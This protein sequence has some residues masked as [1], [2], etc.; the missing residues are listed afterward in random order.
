MSADLVAF[1]RAR[2]D[3]DERVARAVLGAP[4]VRRKDVAGVHADD[5]TD[6]RPDGTP[7]ADCRHVP[8]EYEHKVAVAEHIARHQPARVLAEVEAKRRIVDAY[9]VV[10]GEQGVLREQMRIALAEG[11]EED[12]MRMHRQESNLIERARHLAPATQALA[13]PYAEHPDYREE[14][15]Q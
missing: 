11:R 1:L 9:A 6:D 7:V 15:R 2:L 10:L 13:L 12:F 14:W 4:W 8:A 5:A 3:K